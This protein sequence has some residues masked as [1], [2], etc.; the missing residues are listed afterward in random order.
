MERNI[1]VKK[2]SKENFF[3]WNFSVENREQT[4]EIFHENFQISRE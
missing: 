2:C 4:E 3:C 1:N